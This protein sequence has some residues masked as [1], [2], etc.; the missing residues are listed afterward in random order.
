MQESILPK[1]RYRQ[2]RCITTQ[3]CGEEVPCSDEAVGLGSS[4]SSVPCGGC[5]SGGDTRDCDSLPVE[6]WSERKFLGV[7]CS[8]TKPMLGVIV[9]SK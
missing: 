4:G 1:K 2:N 6:L 7:A 5:L 3:Q 9:I 8:L